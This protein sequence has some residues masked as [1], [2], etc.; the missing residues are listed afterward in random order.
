MYTRIVL[1]VIAALLAV[2]AFR[3][4]WTPPAARAQ[5]SERDLYVEPGTTMLRQPDGSA[6]LRGKVV[7]DLATG[8]VWGF[9]TLADTPYPVDT[10]KTTPPVSHP[11]YLGRFA[12]SEMAGR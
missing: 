10:T 7:V 8:D 12:F 11:M 2:L 6:Q 3:P 4:L 9:P 5:E 1:T